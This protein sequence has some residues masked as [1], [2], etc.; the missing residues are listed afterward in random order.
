MKP[1][2]IFGLAIGLQHPWYIE[3]IEFKDSNKSGGSKELHIYINH[4]RRQKFEVNDKSYSVYDH[5]KRTWRH[6]NFFEHV[7]YLHCNVPR[8]KTNDGN[9]LLVNVPWANPGSSFTLLFEAFSMLLVKGGMSLSGAGKYMNIDGRRIFR[10]ID[11]RVSEALSEQELEQVVEAG[12]DETST[13]KGHNYITVLTDRK[14][15]KVVGLGLGKNKEA[16]QIAVNEM[17]SRGSKAEKV[18]T[19]TLDLS[20]AFISASNKIFE[21]SEIVFDRFHIDQLL[22]RAIDEIRREDQKENKELKKSRY[23]WLKNENNLS[24]INLERVHYLERTYP[25]IGK[26]YRLKE[27]FKEIWNNVNIESTIEDLEEWIILAWASQLTPLQKFV[28]T[29]CDHWYGIESYFRNIQT[30]AYAERVNLKIQEIK[31]IAKGYRNMTNFKSIIYF[32]LGGLDLN[33]PTKNG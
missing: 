19:L 2:E 28:N 33:L 15:K 26:A 11:S 22:S 29:I 31:R 24:N 10:I 5:Q 1:E 30:N 13:K 32:H 9:T 27:Q 4:D 17:E 21:N 16:V 12:L 18:K 14:R 6:L 20:P 23:L 8:V 7:C 3:N 25:R